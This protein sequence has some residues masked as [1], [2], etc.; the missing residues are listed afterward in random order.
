MFRAILRCPR[1][2]QPG[3]LY[4]S[5]GG[6]PWLLT[7]AI[8]FRFR[9]HLGMPE[10]E[11]WLGVRSKMAFGKLYSAEGVIERV[12]WGTKLFNEASD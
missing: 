12:T 3:A 6:D 2:T 7:R 9:P 5:G 4:L 10:A 1:A 8:G 11:T